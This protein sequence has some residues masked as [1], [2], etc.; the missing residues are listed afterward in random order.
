MT[1]KPR[2]WRW[3]FL[4]VAGLGLAL[5]LF[6]SWL[7]A[8][9]M[10]RRA[11][12][13]RP[14]P[15]P[16]LAW[17]TPKE[18]RL[19]T[20]DGQELGAW[21]FAGKSD[22]PAIL[23]LHGNGGTRADCLDQAE[24]LIKA[25]HPVLLITL[26]AHGDSTCDRN[27]FGY[28]AQHDVVAAVEW[29]ERNCPGRPL[30]WGRSLGS[31]AALFASRELGERVSGYVFECPYQDLRTAVRNRTRARLVPPFDW[32]AYTG[33][34]LTAPLVLGDANHISPIDAA[35]NIPKST[36]VLI[37]SGGND[38]RA[39][40]AEAAA[41]GKRIG[42]RA[43]VVVFEGAGHLDLH[44]ADPARYREIGLQFLATCIL[45]NQ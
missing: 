30:V 43:E 9:Q 21:F 18:L 41:I 7:V 27:D 28:S 36:P 35:T 39:T 45:P 26:R 25:G 15:L 40:P 44:R 33:L 5:W 8:D 3:R 14:E 6:T 24:W 34:S 1:P 32:V 16:A 42:P 38:T 2:R 23:L 22:R 13:V 31:A 10:T 29:M 20:V 11:G 19:T 4:I 17:G 37:L 12:R